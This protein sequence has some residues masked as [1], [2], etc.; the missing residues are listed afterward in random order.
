[1]RQNET[2]P[3]DSYNA[4]RSSDPNLCYW[5]SLVTSAWD[6]V[7]RLKGDC[8]VG[9]EYQLS[10]RKKDCEE[11]QS[12]AFLLLQQPSCSSALLGLCGSRRTCFFSFADEHRLHSGKLCLIILTCIAEVGFSCEAAQQWCVTGLYP[13]AFCGAGAEYPQWCRVVRSSGTY[14]LLICLMQYC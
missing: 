1:M 11:S 10:W 12:W 8:L 13:P 5:C 9:I 3:V 4:V 2:I 14:C 7:T 6:L